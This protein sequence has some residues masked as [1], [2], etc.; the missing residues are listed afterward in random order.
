[1]FENLLG[2][3]SNFEKEMRSKLAS[4][5]ISEESGGISIE[6]NGN[7]VITEIDIDSTMLHDN[8]KNELEDLLLVLFNKIQ[9]R[10]AEEKAKKS[11]EFLKTILPGMGNLFK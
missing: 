4:I 6:A 8:S 9:E 3:A 10:C 2:E 11:S 1:M 7:G 5:V